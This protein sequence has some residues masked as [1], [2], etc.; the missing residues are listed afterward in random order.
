ML[1]VQIKNSF[2]LGRFGCQIMIVKFHR[3][4]IRNILM[5]DGAKNGGFA[6]TVGTD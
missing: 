6:N 1:L 4:A 2:S 3:S 5:G